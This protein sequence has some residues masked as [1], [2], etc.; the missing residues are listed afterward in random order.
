VLGQELPAV[1]AVLASPVTLVPGEPA[2]VM[3]ATGANGTVTVT[4]TS[5]GATVSVKKAGTSPTH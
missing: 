4:Y 2:G 3:A 5:A 1:L